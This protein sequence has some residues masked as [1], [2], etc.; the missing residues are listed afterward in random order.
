MLIRSISVEGFTCFAEELR[1]SG[2]SDAINVLYGPNGIGKSSIFRALHTA[3]FRRY[4]AAG[5]PIDDIRP[6]GRPLT[7]KVVL[8]FV[9]A[10]HEY[11]LEKRF[12]Q[13]RSVRID[14][15]EGGRWNPFAES[16]EAERF[17]EAMTGGALGRGGAR[18]FA[19]FAEVLWTSQGDLQLPPL[20]ENVVA[21]IQRSVGEHVSASVKN[22]RRKITEDYERTYTPTGRLK[23]GRDICLQLRFQSECGQLENDVQLAQALVQ[24]YKDAATMIAVLQERVNRGKA[25]KTELEQRF[26]QLRT[27]KEQYRDVKSAFDKRGSECSLAEANLRRVEEC[28]G[29]IRKCRKEEADLQARLGK[30][31]TDLQKQKIA[32]GQTQEQLDK[33]QSRQ[34]EYERMQEAA[35]EAAEA[36]A[37][38]DRYTSAVQQREELKNKIAQIDKTKAELLHIRE[39]ERNVIP[40]THG[41]LTE[42]RRHEAHADRLKSRLESARVN[43]TFVA[44][45]AIC[46]DVQAGERPGPHTVAA[47]ETI[48]LAGSPNL[49]LSIPTLGRLNVSGPVTDY[50]GIAKDHNTESVW[51]RQFAERFGTGDLVELESRRKEVDEWKE[52]INS[53]ETRLQT[54]L[55]SN[56]EAA[57]HSRLTKL[58][59]LTDA[60]EKQYPQW[61]A[62]PPDAVNLHSAAKAQKETVKVQLEQARSAAAGALENY[63][64]ALRSVD[65]TENDIKNT[66]VRIQSARQCLLEA[67]RDGL[68][69]E[70][71]EQ[72]RLR[73]AAAVI[74][75]CEEVKKLAAEL[76]A[77]PKHLEE[78]LVS[79][80][81]VLK[82]LTAAL[83]SDLDSL[84]TGEAQQSV[85]V[86]ENPYSRL[87]T[88]EEHLS[89]AREKLATEQ[90]RNEAILL[91]Y[92]TFSKVME[93]SLSTV[94]EPVAERASRHL[95]F[96]CGKPLARIRLENSFNAVGVIP[97]GCADQNKSV[98]CMSGGEREQI[99]LCTRLALAEELTHQERQLVILDDVL[100]VTDTDRMARIC[101][102]LERSANRLQIILLT[103]QPERFRRLR[104]ANFIDLFEVIK[105]KREAKEI[106]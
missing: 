89:V 78:E 12:V 86:Q 10:D 93:D 106:A 84:I 35:H 57:I 45:R 24:T 53:I 6:W 46:I 2:F 65:R 41:E 23:T 48:T 38:A 75:Y 26:E 77:F 22:L 55:Q 14:R 54:L 50:D 27:Q 71:R 68:S 40:P 73:A 59:S 60:L 1:L 79:C 36:A 52:R 56:S 37:A 4:N 18:E 69:D 49:N 61:A 33:A 70:Q 66:S 44:E 43:V 8:E 90:R 85:L 92:N 19:G 28:I 103:C 11:R 20:G 39:Q 31:S 64:T 102:L 17:L 30:L 72:D 76:E 87:S 25:R 99:Y 9:R 91:L 74:T 32:L 105:Q 58:A 29:T 82:D 63:Q 96:V 62:N 15:R 5:A 81:R 98:N 21:T 3:L 42:L 80:E 100:T 51:L 97:D 104:N 16:D 7:P 83:R 95:E 34:S 13:L 88:A 101:E 94:A 47:G 67:L